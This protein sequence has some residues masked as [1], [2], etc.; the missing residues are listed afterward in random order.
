MNNRIVVAAA[1]LVVAFLLGFVPMYVK[2]NRLDAELRTA[3][4]ENSRAEL[5]DL[6]ALAYVQAS[7]QNYGLAASTSSRFFDRARELANQTQDASRKALD[8][9]LAFRDKV[10]AKLAKGDAAALADL[11]DLFVKTRQATATGR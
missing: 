6:I 7:Q 5:R 9:L 4:A 11:Q 10:T 8:E 1:A 3:Q 2:A